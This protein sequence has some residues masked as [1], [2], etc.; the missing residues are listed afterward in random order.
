MAVHS[1][2][3]N[4]FPIED[5]IS[6]PKIMAMPLSLHNAKP[7]LENLTAPSPL[8]PGKADFGF[9]LSPRKATKKKSPSPK[10]RNGKRLQPS[11]VVRRPHPRLPNCPQWSFFSLGNHT[12][13]GSSAAS[14]PP[15]A[16]NRVHEELT[17][18]TCPLTKQCMRS[19]PA[20]S[21][22]AGG[23]TSERFGLTGVLPSG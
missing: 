21:S 5:A 13:A 22:A 15:R 10:N 6:A 2:L 1:P 4:T 8:S 9:P 19:A 23:G 18:C 17:R 20:L 11:Y 3:K 14:I 16:A 7:F 12:R